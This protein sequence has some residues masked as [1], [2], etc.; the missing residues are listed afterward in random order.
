MSNPSRSLISLSVVIAGLSVVSSAAA[1]AEDYLQ[2]LPSDSVVTLR[3]ATLER[4]DDQLAA[5]AEQFGVVY[6][7]LGQVVTSLAGI[8]AGGDAIAGLMWRQETLVPFALLPVTDYSTFVRAADGDSD[9][10]TTLVTLA[11]EDLVA[12][13]RGRWVLLTN[14]VDGDEPAPL[15]NLPAKQQ[16]R[17]AALAA[18]SD[19]ELLVL[20]G[21]FDQ[22]LA[23]NSN[24][25]VPSRELAQLRRKV[26]NGQVQY[27]DPEYWKAVYRLYRVAFHHLAAKCDGF[28]LGVSVNEEREVTLKAALLARDETPRVRIGEVGS[29]AKILNV[30]GQ[31]TIVSVGGPWGS[32]WTQLSLDLYVYSFAAGSDA[33]GI[34]QFSQPAMARYLKLCKTASDLVEYQSLVIISPTGDR[35]IMSNSAVLLHTT[36]AKTFQDSFDRLIDV[37]NAAVKQSRREAEFVYDKDAD[38]LKGLP[39]SVTGTRYSVDLSNAFRMQNVPDVRTMFDKMYGRNGKLVTDVLAIDNRRVLVSDLPDDL[40]NEL[41]KGLL[42]DSLEPAAAE[43]SGRGEWQVELHPAPLQEWLNRSKLISHGGNIIG[44]E[45]KEF[46]S[47]EKVAI[48]IQ[49]EPAKLEVSTTLSAELV[50]ALGDLIRD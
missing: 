26:Q 22:V 41:V 15:G 12:S 43:E 10:D 42:D 3:V 40:R 30:G 23:S 35:P 9:A 24:R 37:W 6:P 18:D 50:E 49:A 46:A 44:W 4:M 47:D 19:Y 38:D 33:V 25:R 7:P 8:D 31:P 36:N 21:G 34:E 29:E 32:K 1:E 45:P 2:Q 16:S 14:L 48:R 13:R 11:G 5:L 20:R 17:L 27:R 28:S 39:P